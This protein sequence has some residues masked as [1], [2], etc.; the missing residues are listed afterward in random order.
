MSPLT[1]RECL[2]EFRFVNLDFDVVGPRDGRSI[3]ILRD[4]QSRQ[5]AIGSIGHNV[6][7]PTG[8][9]NGIA[10]AH[11][12]SVSGVSYRRWR[13][14]HLGIIER[15][16]CQLAASTVDIVKQTAVAFVRI[17]RLQQKVV[18][19]ELNASSGIPGSLFQITDS[20]IS[21]RVWLNGKMLP[22][23]NGLVRS[24]LT[25]LKSVSKRLAFQNFNASDLSLNSRSHQYDDNGTERQNLIHSGPDTMNG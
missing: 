5:K 2:T 16:Q 21:C 1:E 19:L 11:Q 25:K 13:P 14:G 6:S 10:F 18:R 8:P 15:P 17:G 23:G 24:R 7:I 3:R 22:T 20:G 9:P 12:K 4:R